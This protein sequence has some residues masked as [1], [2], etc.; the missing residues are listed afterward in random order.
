MARSRHPQRK[1]CR[2]YGYDYNQPGAYFVTICTHHRECLFGE[3]DAGVM[4]LNESG[5]HVQSVWQSLPTHYS[6]IG[7]DTFVIMPNHV[8]GILWVGAIHESPP[9]TTPDHGIIPTTGGHG[10]IPK[11]R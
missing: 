3:V 5:N 9:T 8:H 4:V 2:L 7:L 1:S 6:N 11:R 10:A